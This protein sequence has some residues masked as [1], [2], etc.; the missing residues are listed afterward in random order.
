MPLA[1][2]SR[3]FRYVSRDTSP[4]FIVLKQLNANGFAVF[5]A[6]L[7][8]L[9]MAIYG[10]ELALWTGVFICGGFFNLAPWL[11]TEV[12]E[13]R[14]VRQDELQERTQQGGLDDVVQHQMPSSTSCFRTPA[15][16]LVERHIPR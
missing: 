4:F 8:I 15:S 11:R 3:L 6:E 7:N 12:S 5:Q 10:I 13:R 1:I 16:V 9:G 2:Y 14:Q